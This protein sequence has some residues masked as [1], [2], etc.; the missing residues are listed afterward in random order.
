MQYL[1]GHTDAVY[2]LA[3]SQ[4]GRHLLTGSGDETARLWDLGTGEEIARCRTERHAVHHSLVVPGQ[5]P[6]QALVGTGNRLWHWELGT[7]R[8]ALFTPDGGVRG[9]A[10]QPDGA[11]LASVGGRG[12]E[13]VRRWR[14]MTWELIDHWAAGRP[15]TACLAFSTDGASL[16]T[17]GDDAVLLWDAAG[18][19][20]GMLA[21]APAVGFS[22]FVSRSPWLVTAS[23]LSLTVWDTATGSVLA[24]H[25][26]TGKHY[27]GI[28]VSPDAGLMATAN[29]EATVRLHRLPGLDETAAT[30]VNIDPDMAVA[31]CPARQRYAH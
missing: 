11:A 7:G 2:A 3:F 19:V 15:L 23:S 22:A 5:A 13:G 18:K 6:L 26:H 1:K 4:D 17:A 10:F 9:L 16:A 30:H 27:Q 21:P 29:N 24:T 31:V 25:R 8:Q 28:A 12:G 20:T 14:P